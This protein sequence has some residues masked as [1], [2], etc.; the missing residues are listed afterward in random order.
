[1]TVLDL[2]LLLVS[3]VLSAFIF[4]SRLWVL[5]DYAFIYDQIYCGVLRGFKF[6]ITGGIITK[7]YMR[8]EC[9]MQMKYKSVIEIRAM[10]YLISS[11]MHYNKPHYFFSFLLTL[12][13]FSYLLLFFCQAIFFIHSLSIQFPVLANATV[14]QYDIHH[15]FQ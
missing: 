8:V 10:N 12:L 3:V 9:K 6:L 15:L 4:R 5:W 13:Y 14:V 1:M 7:K 2:F 11:L